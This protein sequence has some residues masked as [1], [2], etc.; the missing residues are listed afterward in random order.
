MKIT[1]YSRSSPGLILGTAT[2]ANAIGGVSFS[3]NALPTPGTILVAISS[4]MFEWRDALA[5]GSNTNDVSSVGT[6]GASASNTRADHVHRGV[7][8]ISHTSNTF[9]GDVTLTASGGLG[10]TVP[11]PGTLNLSAPTSAGGGGGG[12]G[13]STVDQD[14]SADFTTASDNAWHDITGLTGISLADGTWICY[15]DIETAHSTH[16]GPVFRVWDGTTVYAQAGILESSPITSAA[17]THWHF[18]S[19][20][21]VLGG[22]ATMAV[23]VFSDTAFAIKKYPLRGADT[24]VVATHVTFLKIA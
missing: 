8:S 3:S 12:G 5:F 1:D 15:V 24:T 2:N 21:F 23:Q 17:S 18:N 7:H 10:I 6:M 20:P 13:V 4:N 19:K 22:S 11:T 14:I 9:Y 16:Y